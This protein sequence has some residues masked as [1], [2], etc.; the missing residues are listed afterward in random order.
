MEEFLVEF[1]FFESLDLFNDGFEQAADLKFNFRV[2][3]QELFPDVGF[4]SALFQVENV[5]LKGIAF[6]VFQKFSAGA[7]VEAADEDV[8]F[9][10]NAIF[11]DSAVGQ[12]PDLDEATCRRRTTS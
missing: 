11:P 10:R 12:F 5:D 2:E 8:K 3:P 7:F 4:G 1:R 9:V 6:L